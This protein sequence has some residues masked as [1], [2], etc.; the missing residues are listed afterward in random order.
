MRLREILK[1]PLLSHDLWREY[2][3]LYN[4][5]ITLLIY[6]QTTYL[7]LKMPKENIT[8]PNVYLLGKNICTYLLGRMDGKLS[9]KL[10]QAL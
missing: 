10:F 4:L 1:D 5:E 8:F 9:I 6:L 2:K 7:L 3:L